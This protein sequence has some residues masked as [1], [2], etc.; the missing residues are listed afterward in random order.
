MQ[1]SAHAIAL[2]LHVTRRLS[3]Q[4]TRLPVVCTQFYTYTFSLPV[5]TSM[6]LRRTYASCNLDILD[7]GGPPQHPALSS[8]LQPSPFSVSPNPLL[9]GV[10]H[11]AGGTGSLH[12]T[13]T[14]V[15]LPLATT[16]TQPAVASS[17]LTRA[18]YPPAAYYNR[19]QSSKSSQTTMKSV[20]FRTNAASPIPRQS[21]PLAP[22]RSSLVGRPRFPRSKSEPSLYRKA[23]ML[24]FKRSPRGREFF[25]RKNFSASVAGA[26]TESKWTVV[27]SMQNGEGGGLL[28]VPAGIPTGSCIVA[29][30]VDWEVVDGME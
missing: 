1:N 21:S 3:T 23:L 9:T 14:L 11:F 26:V 28:Q 30:G 18:S 25:R 29:P 7:D 16:T 10:P 27:P 12:G 19:L 15:C 17:A 2:T 5:G 4:I 22:Y 8:H 13:G 20:P 6:P 24:R